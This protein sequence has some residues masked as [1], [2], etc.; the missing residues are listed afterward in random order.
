MGHCGRTFDADALATCLSPQLALLVHCTHDSMEVD[1][2]TW[3]KPFQQRQGRVVHLDSDGKV[4]YPS[5]FEKPKDF[6]SK[7]FLLHHAAGAR[8]RK[9]ER[10]QMPRDMVFLRDMCRAAIDFTDDLPSVGSLG[11]DTSS[12]CAGCFSDDGAVQ[13]CCCLLHW[14]RECAITAS[15]GMTGFMRRNNI[16][17]LSEENVASDELPFFLLCGTQCP[18]I[19][20]SLRQV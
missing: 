13:C 7:S 2:A 5:H 9:K 20:R 8:V 18:N 10:E 1:F 4:I 12:T 14:H 11:L 6:S 3:V 17:E 19:D 15:E 16:T